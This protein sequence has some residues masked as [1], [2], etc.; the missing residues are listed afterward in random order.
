MFCTNCGQKLSDNSKICD[1][2]GFIIKNPP[3]SEASSAQTGQ[4]QPSVNVNLN[5]NNSLPPCKRTKPLTTAN[6]FFTQVLFLIPILNIFFIIYWSFKKNINENLK[7]YARSMLIW[8]I[9]TAI[10]CV[11]AL[12]T[13]AFIQSPLSINFKFSN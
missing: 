9:I 8:T 10:I 6:F 1:N 2:C 13:F 11:F 3:Q 4:A 12:L 5:E 7:S